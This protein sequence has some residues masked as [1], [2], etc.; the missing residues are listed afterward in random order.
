MAKKQMTPEEYKAKLEVKAAKS[1]RF[2]N[3]FLSS[4][5]V[6][7]AVVITFSLVS[8]SYTTMG[9]VGKTNVPSGTVNNG[10]ATNNNGGV[11]TDDAVI[12]DTT[13]PGDTTV[14]GGDATTPGGDATT[15][16]N[17]GAT[18][19]P[20]ATN[21]NQEILDMYK[22]AVN[23][24]R[25]KSKSVIRVK[26][27]AINY[28]GIVEAGGLSS[29]ASSLMGMFMAKD[30]ASIEEKNEQWEKEKL[31]N[32][33]ALTLNGLQ[34]ISRQDKG[35]TYVITV[36]AK[37]AVNPKANADGVGSVAGVIEESQITGAIGSVPGLKLSNISI[38]YENVTAV[39][40]VDKATGNL[41]ALN[42][43]APCVLG[44]DAKLAVITMN[45]AKV[46]I[47]VITEYKIS[48]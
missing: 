8:I 3:V 39:A 19:T 12:G 10:G 29:A 6:L 38:A 41:I 35:N 15:P 11:S 32:A 1:E 22:K 42:I 5:A 17:S 26:D 2:S 13:I 43:N 27:G 24:A 4:I 31:P 16:D 30:E 28:K 47:Q 33:S 25:T 18:T 36:V 21:E 48:Y 45:G 46:G 37:N 23:A 7:L 40:T 20:G 14:P 44:L 9:M 34:K